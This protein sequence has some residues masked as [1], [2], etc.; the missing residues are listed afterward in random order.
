[1]S[2]DELL[3]RFLSEEGPGAVRYGD[4]EGVFKS[5]GHSFVGHEGPYCTWK[6]PS[7]SALLTLRDEGVQPMYSKYTD[8][9]AKHLKAVKQRGDSKWHA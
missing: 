2:A 3:A 5:V 6:H 4:L 7:Y 9:A 1:M 8:K